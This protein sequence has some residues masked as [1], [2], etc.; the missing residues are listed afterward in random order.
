[1]PLCFKYSTVSPFPCL[2]K[3]KWISGETELH[4][5]VYHLGNGLI[6][7]PLLA[8]TLVLMHCRPVTALQSNVGTCNV[9]VSKSFPRSPLALRHLFISSISCIRCGSD[10]E[11]SQCAVPALFP[12]DPDKFPLFS[13]RLHDTLHRGECILSLS[14]CN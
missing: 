10:L 3:V 1:M 14:H 12:R 7:S 4:D 13:G 5:N 9:S 2:H 11:V 6:F 8:A